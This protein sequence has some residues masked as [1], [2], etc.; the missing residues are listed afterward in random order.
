M[1]KERAQS[2]PGRAVNGPLRERRPGPR[3]GAGCDGRRGS[4]ADVGGDCHDPEAEH[5]RGARRQ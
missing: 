5:A 3:L 4:R 2:P 1:R